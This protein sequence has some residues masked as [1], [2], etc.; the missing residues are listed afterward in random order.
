LLA[1]GLRL[2]S[3]EQAKHLL[4]T[5]LRL[6]SAEQAKPAVAFILAHYSC[7]VQ[8]NL[9]MFSRVREILVSRQQDVQLSVSFLKIWVDK[10]SEVFIFI[11][12]FYEQPT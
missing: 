11:E 10:V 2:H 9:G 12:G 7:G 6:H 1:T 4:A 3:A 5:G 8:V